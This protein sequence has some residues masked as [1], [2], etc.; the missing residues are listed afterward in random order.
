MNQDGHIARKHI[1]RYRPRE[2]AAISDP[3]QFFTTLGAAISDQ[4]AELAA[5]LAGTL[6]DGE[7]FLDRV[8]R[9]NTAQTPP[10][11]EEPGSPAGA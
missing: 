11:R 8:G 2:Y 7:S 6:A 1:A 5:E 10:E 9:Q 3:E 4:I